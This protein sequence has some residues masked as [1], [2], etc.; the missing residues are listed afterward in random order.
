MKS[1]LQAVE[2]PRLF[3]PWFKDSTWAAWRA[4]LAA[5][6]GLPMTPDQLALFTQCTGR[7]VAPTGPARE[8]WLVCGRRAG[9]S[10]ILALI[11]VYFAT[12]RDYARYLAPGERGTLLIL[13]ADRKQ[14]RVIFRYISALLKQVPMLARMI[15]NERAESFDLTNR[16]TIE[17]GTASYRT[18]RGYTF[19]AVLCDELAFWRSDDSASPD[20]EVI[21]AIRPG[22]L[23]I[24]N[25]M[26]LCASS[27]Y[28][29]RGALWDAYTEFFG[30]DNPDVLVWQAPTTTM[31]PTVSQSFI[32]GE[33][34]CDPAGAAAEY[35]AQFRTDVEAFITLEAIRACVDPGV[36]ERPYDRRNAYFAFVDPSGGSADSFVLVVAH[37]EAGKI[38]IDCIRDRR[39]PLSPDQVTAEFAD[40]LKH[41]R[42][43]KVT[44]DNYGGEFP[45][46]AFR[47]HGI[48]YELADKSKSKL[49][50]DF[51]PLVNSKQI[52]LLDSDRMVRQFVGLE[53]RTNWG[54]RDSIDHGPG[55]HDD[56]ANAVA[57]VCGL[58]NRSSDLWSRLVDAALTDSVK[59]AWPMSKKEPADGNN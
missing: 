36:Y 53:R 50:F 18:T 38:V 3:A 2:D 32:D 20:Y 25:S 35:L 41:Y 43:S 6:F 56:V 22:M 11:A 23:T 47:K 15:E 48:N 39:S 10:F 49:Y 12:F 26:L 54:G 59:P 4:W 29:R 44:G 42:I 51:L 27:P 19:V 24:P 5:L 34:E 28:A 57:G 40:T 30:K 31:N 33:L 45:K 13:A 14:S 21:N 16:V 55:G 37:S 52:V 7:S 8:G 17:V 1:I 46:E 9:K 58:A